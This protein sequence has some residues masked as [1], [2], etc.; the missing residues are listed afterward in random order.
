MKFIIKILL[1]I[2]SLILVVGLRSNAIFAA[3]E[4]EVPTITLS[5]EKRGDV[6]TSNV[7]ITLSTNDETL[8]IQYKLFSGNM[9]RDWSTYDN[10]VTLTVKGEYRIIVRSVN[11]ANKRSEEKIQDLTIEKKTDESYPNV[12][13]DG[14][15]VNHIETNTPI[16]LPE[17]VEKE[18]MRGVWVATVSY[19]DVK[20]Y[21]SDAQYKRQLLNIL[22]NVQAHNMNAIFFQVRPMNDAFYESSYAPYSR[23][24]RGT[25]GQGLDW[26][27][28]EF[29]VT[30]AHE[31]GIE[32]HAWLNPYRVSNTKGVD[33]AVQL[34]L[35]DDKNFAKKNPNLVIED[36]EGALILNP[37]EPRV[38]AYLKSVIGEL[39]NNYDID[40]IHFDDYFYSYGGTA[41]S[42][43]QSAFD[44][45]NPDNLS[46]DDWRRNNV[47]L[48]VKDVFQYIENHNQ[49]K[50]DSIKFG[51]SPFG[52]WANKQTNPLGSPT[53]GGQSYYQP[54]Y[55]DSRKWVL[56]GWLH[57][58]MPQVYW[59]FNRDVAPFA[60]IVDWWADIAEQGGVDLIIGHGFY[61][62]LE[63]NTD[64]QDTAE[65]VE[66]VRYA[67]THPVVKGSVFFSYRTM[68]NPSVKVESSLERLNDSYWTRP[69]APP[70]ETKA[71]RPENM[72]EILL[73]EELFTLIE[74]TKVS[75]NE[76]L[77]AEDYENLL[78]DKQYVYLADLTRL[79]NYLVNLEELL[80]GI[81]YED[82]LITE[83]NNLLLEIQIFQMAIFS[84]DYEP[85]SPE[86]QQL[87]ANLAAELDRI[88]LYRNSVADAEN[89]LATELESGKYFAS[90]HLLTALDQAMDMAQDLLDSEYV[91]SVDLTAQ[92]AELLLKETELQQGALLGEFTLEQLKVRLTDKLSVAEDLLKNTQDSKGQEAIKLPKGKKYAPKKELDDLALAVN[93]AKE[94]LKEDSNFAELSTALNLIEEKEMNLLNETIIGSKKGSST[95]KIVTIVISSIVGS[96]ALAAGVGGV[97]LLFK[98][99]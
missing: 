48:M 29:M 91:L 92:L 11:P 90:L 97:L 54:Q 52:I 44:K 42:Q 68:T 43:D 26:D 70:W 55:A 76:V 40:G 35:L 86:K 30:E 56:E 69:V 16:V 49:N 24:I 87:K 4:V 47:D 50:N 22:D 17:Y 15:I 28:L 21:E 66:Q 94:L 1:L 3:E 41:N 8:T 9:P 78:F 99:K 93:D 13:R 61:R 75:R 96:A 5:G 74:Q 95:A 23:Y 67:T 80:S 63:S 18:E 2:F 7:I 37:G 10:P 53:R 45:Y 62:I 6:Y 71:V 32:L 58:I 73:K 36:N 89:K 46:R 59:G 33:K 65:L 81:V 79:D 19:I 31:R 85:D 82:V 98:K 77:V 25:E 39:M 34:A 64:W 60:D 83:K 20:I 57:Y 12:I 27:I 72:T 84:G 51:I 88:I 38:R 14:T